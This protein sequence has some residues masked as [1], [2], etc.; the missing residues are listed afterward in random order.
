VIAIGNPLG[1]GGSVTAGIVSALDRDIHETRFDSFIQTD[2]AINH[3]NSGG[4]LFN[5]TGEV[6]GVDTA[7]IS[8]TSGSVGLGFAIP[9]KDAQYVANRLLRDGSIRPAYLGLKIEEVTQ[10]MAIALGM[11]RPMGSIVALVHDG[12]PA[13]KAGVQVGDVILRYNNETLADERAMLRAFAKSDI[14]KPVPI[15]VLRAGKEL[16]L[17]VT[18]IAWPN[19]ESTSG[20]GAGQATKVAMLVPPNLGLSLST[21]TSDLRARYGL[22]MHQPGVLID[23]VAAGT[24]AFDR[25][26]VPGDVILRLQDTEVASPQQVQA[27]IDAARAQHKTFILALVQSKEPAIPGP[28]WMAL[29]VSAA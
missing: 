10:D 14:G 17:Q 6:I 7:I 4:P 5:R 9:A 21:L 11:P 24:D 26:L 28:R 2:A 29:R 20:T 1:L 16:T 19:T 22:H 27:A 18:P 12:H 23:G 3:G 13:A 8:P 25:G 15:T